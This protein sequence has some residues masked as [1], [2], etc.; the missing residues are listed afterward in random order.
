MKKMASLP[1]GSN[2]IL[3]VHTKSVSLVI[4]SKKKQAFVDESLVMSQN[5]SVEVTA[6]NIGRLKIDN[7]GIDNTYDE[8]T[9]SLIKV[10]VPPLFFEQ[11]DYEIVIQSKD[12][13]PVSF[14]H[15][16]QRIREKISTVIDENPGLISG[17]VNFGNNVGFSD[18]E[19]MHDGHTSLI[20]R[21]EVYPSKISY[22]E[23][24]KMML[25]DISEEI[26]SAVIDFLQKTY[27]WISIGNSRESVPALFFQ[28]IST[29]FDRYMKAAK[30]IIASPHHKLMVE[31]QVMPAHKARKTDAM[32]EKW[33]AKHPEYVKRTTNGI[34]AEKVLAVRKQITYDTTENQ[35][36]KFIL[37]STIKQLNEFKKRYINTADSVDETVVAKAD[38]MISSIKH[39]VSSSFLEEVS[40]YKATQSMSLVF[41]MAPGY[42]E[43]YKYYLM[44]QRGLSINGDVFK[45]SMKDTAQLYEYWCF[46]KLVSIMKKKNYKLFTDD[47][48]KVSNKGITVTL[49][50]GQASEVKFIN[51]RTG[52]KIS[53]TYNPSERNTPTVN[54]KPDN[55]LTLEKIGAEREYKYVFD[56]KYRIESNPD[57][58]YPD[59]NIGPK[60]DDINTMHRYRD[61]I[62]Y[63]DSGSQFMFKKE[64]FG[65]YV[66]FPYADEEQYKAHHF[67]KSIDTVNIGG[68]PF[69]PGATTL[70]EKMLEELIADSDESAFE[71]ASLPAGIEK[72]LS[73]VDWSQ[74]DVLVGSFGSMEQFNINIDKRFY[75]V[76]ARVFDRSHLPIRYVALYQSANMFKNDAGIRYYGE[77]LTTS[78]VKRKDIPV[79][80]KRNNGDE[81]Y[82]AFRV[83]EWKSLPTPIT[84]KDEG[85]REPRYT[86]MFLLE[87]CTQSYELF[88]IHSDAQYRLLH[89]LKRMFSDATVNA[90]SKAE[91]IY[92]V[93][94]GKS[95]WVHEG[96]FDILNE[97][98]ERLFDPPL[99]ISDF[100][101]HP[102]SYFS[103][104]AEKMENKTD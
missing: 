49:V 59:S 93:D 26:Y 53:L 76:P 5:S 77:V 99:R 102:R 60:L 83:R 51:P 11:T 9:Q 22:K 75:Y 86:N 67:Y 50:K 52:E 36:T 7:C 54:Q 38:Y 37:N 80:M 33:L 84:V 94:N 44:L 81:D 96:Y 17:I 18:F 1:I 16:N 40:E 14:W 66:L 101:R 74:Y 47:V 23:D 69:L 30:T 57:A 89:E 91:P 64:M 62:V 42:R 71:R 3:E 12:G 21:L 34:N 20:V 70:V 2:K 39:S 63:S 98:G 72:R 82:Y 79:T 58:Y 56:A 97:N 45:M 35:F 90:N 92:Q 28:I 78:K 4:K 88:N 29:I 46:I 41:G 6:A 61:S 31:H 104:I 55:V 19:I 48:I 68:L 95:I 65:A 13:K 10:E 87:H 32:S 24:Y 15:E 43:L 103:M 73:Q 27:E 8:T 85:V 100:A 25:E